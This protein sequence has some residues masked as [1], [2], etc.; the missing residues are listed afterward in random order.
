MTEPQLHDQYSILNASCPSR[1]VL[2]LIA[3]KW[4]VLVIH[5]IDQEVRRY[6]EL[7]RMID[8]ISQKM[9]TQTLRQ[10]EE[11]G[12]V[13]RVV[14]PVIPPKVEYSL[15]ELGKTLIEAVFV[16]KQWAEDNIAEVESAKV[17]YQVAKDESTS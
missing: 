14:Y 6:N 9:L 2:D 5:A 15:T 17:A 12:L 3:D 8:G 7:R 4:T 13:K 16:V 10:L 11:N 1:Q